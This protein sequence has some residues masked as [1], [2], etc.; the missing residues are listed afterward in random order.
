MKKL[1]FII[2]IFLVVFT[3]YSEQLS[4]DYWN[5]LDA[6]QQESCINGF[7][8]GQASILYILHNNG[9]TDASKA[10]FEMLYC[11]LTIEEIAKGITAFYTIPKYKD[12]PLYIAFLYVIGVISQNDNI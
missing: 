8:Y 10:I 2:I 5:S 3:A 11:E 4:S 12:E 9:A 6:E 1:L 7:I